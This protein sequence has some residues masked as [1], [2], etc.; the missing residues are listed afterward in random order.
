M[1]RKKRKGTKKYT[2]P[3]KRRKVIGFYTDEKG[4]VRPITKSVGFLKRPIT[5]S[6]RNKNRK[7]RT[8]RAVRPKPFT[9]N[10]KYSKR[11]GDGET[12]VVISTDYQKALAEAYE[13]KVDPRNPIEIEIIDPDL[14]KVLSIIA[15]GAKKVAAIGGKFVVKGGHIAKQLALKT[16]EV[17][18]KGVVG[19]GKIVGKA[20]TSAG[21]LAAMKLAERRYSSTVKRLVEKAY[22]PNPAERVLARAKLREQYPDIYD[23]CDFSKT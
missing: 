17:A 10:F 2:P 12:V 19:T 7:T 11:K 20:V 4:R 9:V 18:G 15:S 3:S 22:S 23:I 5:S 14:G 16:A 1:P 8:R 13:E 21:K 6:L